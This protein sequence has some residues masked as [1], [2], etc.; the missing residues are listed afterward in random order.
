MRRIACHDDSDKTRVCL[1]DLVMPGI[2]SRTR[3]VRALCVLMCVCVCKWEG[4]R[5]VCRHNSHRI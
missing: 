1:V 2:K 5:V 4:V 3:P